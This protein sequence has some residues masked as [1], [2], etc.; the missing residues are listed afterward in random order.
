MEPDE[1]KLV[2]VFLQ[3]LEERRMVDILDKG[4]AMLYYVN[5]FSLN[6]VHGIVKVCDCEN[7]GGAV[8]QCVRS[9]LRGC[10]HG[11]GIWIQ[12]TPL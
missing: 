12:A 7:L 3:R 8:V 10:M 1:S 9:V 6:L 2:R 5:E 4:H 11:V